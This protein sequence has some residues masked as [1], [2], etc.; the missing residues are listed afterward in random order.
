MIV[1][2]ARLF[3]R[4]LRLGLVAIVSCVAATSAQPPVPTWERGP[5]VAFPP[6]AQR[7]TDGV[8][9]TSTSWDPDGASGY[10]KPKLVIGGSF[11][12]AGAASVANVALW[13]GSNWK[14]L[15]LGFNSAVQTL[16]VFNGELYAG[17]NFTA[18]GSTACLRIAKFNTSTGLWGPVAGGFNDI[19]LALAEQNGFLVA[20]GAFTANASGSVP[21]SRI[22]RLNAGAWQAMP[23]GGVNGTI[24][25][26]KSLGTKLYVGGVFS[27][28][29]TTG[30]PVRNLASWSSSF[31]WEDVNGGTDG[32]VLALG[33]SSSRLLVGGNFTRVRNNTI[34]SP[35]FAILV[36]GSPGIWISA[37][38]FPGGNVHAILGEVVSP[39][40][41]YVGTEIAPNRSILYRFNGTSWTLVQNAVGGQIDTIFT[42]SRHEDQVWVGG[43][44][45]LFQ[46]SLT[47]N[48]IA[49]VNEFAPSLIDPIAP[50]WNGPIHTFTPFGGNLIAGGDFEQSLEDYT[51]VANV[52]GFAH[53]DL[54]ASY[55]TVRGPV[56]ALRGV[57]GLAT[58]GSLYTGG[59]FDQAG[60][61]S[62]MNNVATYSGL[63]GPG[64]PN[65]NWD[66]V[67]SGF[68]STVGTPVVR[69]FATFGGTINSPTVYAAGSFTH[70]ASTAVRN[71]ARR[72][73]GVWV[74]LGAG[75][76]SASG[77]EA[78]NALASFGGRL[79]ATGFFDTADGLVANSFA[80]YNGTS[81]ST[82]ATGLRLAAA[83]G[84]G[85]ALAV[86]GGSL[87]VA[88]RFDSAGGLAV[89][90]VAAWNGT[91]WSNFSTGL[92]NP[93][94]VASAL[95]VYN[96]ELY[97]ATNE[98]VAFNSIV[99]R[100][101]RWTGSAWSQVA[102]TTD[103]SI[104]A[105][106]A[107]RNKLHV[108]GAFKR[109]NAIESH[110]WA[111]IN[112]FCLADVDDGS[113]FGVADGGVTIDDLLYYLTQFEAGSLT[114]DV[115]NG[116][117]SGVADGGVTID[118]LLYYLV[119]F[120][121]GC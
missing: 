31:S 119:R 73:G 20:A 80:S 6:I 111:I 75:V 81:W 22:G 87:I 113:G 97:L 16:L 72:S 26:M 28:A 10:Q 64:G 92:T 55:G 32:A 83:K 67:A 65:D 107:F 38:N 104:L 52:V 84:T 103:H 54:F 96:S 59:T 45:N 4:M 58:L 15:G 63:L 98:T 100:I 47:L 21:M 2:T 76:A 11:S 33:E 120:E 69:A 5:Q 101:Y 51:S 13:D 93:N 44:F 62:G 109:A 121:Q 27:T 90:N 108:G 110:R 50:R 3:A 89:N 53:A 37:L 102:G 49:R 42:L 8:V 24:L 19:V 66:P 60:F 79:Y 82:H 70:S 77:P 86:F 7:G 74:A 115:D 48:N 68:S 99:G 30:L 94:E 17:G 71:I 46:G 41:I 56:Y 25:A 36:T 40:D 117:G 12:R 114:A 116:F 29:G 112:R 61:F 1:S 91:S 35:K 18:S 95:A 105:L 43:D 14:P 118:D 106:A 9:F 57:S 85:N 34:S 39:T 78:V 88:G 23:G